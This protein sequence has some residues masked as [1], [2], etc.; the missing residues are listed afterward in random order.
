MKVEFFLAV[1]WS[2][3]YSLG[4]PVFTAGLLFS[5]R[6]SRGSARQKEMGLSGSVGTSHLGSLFSI[7]EI[8]FVEYCVRNCLDWQ[9]FGHEL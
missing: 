6:S 4:S 3:A 7:K 9:Q 1:S 5:R 2:F 8:V